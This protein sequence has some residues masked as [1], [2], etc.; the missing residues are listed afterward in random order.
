MVELKGFLDYVLLFSM[1]ALLGGIGGLGFE[2]M[3]TRRGQTG[4]VERPHRPQAGNYTDWGV[5]A[6]I[7]IGAI[8][9]VAVL[10]VFPPEDKTTVT[11]DGKT[12][13]TTQ[14]DIVKLVGLSLIVGSAGSSFLS[15]L[16]A[17][18]LARVKGQEAQITRQVAEGQIASL[19]ADIHAD[20]SKERLIGR[21]E[22]AKRAVA[23]S[24]DSSI[25]NPTVKDF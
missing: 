17:K 8:A 4:L 23:E 18:A 1:A 14:F 3:Q 15:A 7:I 22:A 9:A 25:G 20:A 24:G 5:V 6:N 19:E 13:I 16:Q 11:A 21:V 12:T 2:L 10:W